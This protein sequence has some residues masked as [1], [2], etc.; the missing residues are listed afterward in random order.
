MRNS[1]WNAAI[2]VLCL[3]LHIFG[4]LASPDTTESERKNTDDAEHLAGADMCDNQH[5]DEIP[6]ASEPSAPPELPK[7]DF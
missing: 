6:T 7:Q 5:P 1:G 2:F 4:G 3:G